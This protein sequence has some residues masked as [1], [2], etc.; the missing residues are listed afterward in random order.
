[1]RTQDRG[2]GRLEDLLG[3]SWALLGL[4]VDPSDGLPPAAQAWVDGRRAA[5]LTI[6]RPGQEAHPLSSCPVVEDL[7]GTVLR[8]MSR[9]DRP[10]VA[11][12][13]PDRYVLGVFPPARLPGMPTSPGNP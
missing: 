2:T 8:M 6:S 13:R 1:V 12:V 4:G 3:P 7:D 10:L 9:R 5:L 11:V